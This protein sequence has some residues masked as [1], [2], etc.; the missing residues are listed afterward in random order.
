[1][2]TE[3]KQQ[4]REGV[5]ASKPVLKVAAG[6]F[7][8]GVD[9]LMTSGLLHDSVVSCNNL[10]TCEQSLINKVIESLSAALLQEVNDCLK[11]ALE[12]P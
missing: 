4:D 5:F 11:A 2:L 9:D 12:L 3:A 1:M 10:A 6:V 8:D 7:R